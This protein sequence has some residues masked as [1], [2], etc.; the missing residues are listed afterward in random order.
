MLVSPFAFNQD[1]IASILAVRDMSK[2]EREFIEHI[3]I[4]APSDILQQYAP[5]E[6]L[7]LAEQM[8]QK[9]AV[10][11]SQETIIEFI[12]ASVPNKQIL[13]IVTEDKAFLVD[14]IKALLSSLNITA[15][16]TLHP[17]IKVKRN[18]QG[19]LENIYPAI[20]EEEGE[21]ESFFFTELTLGKQITYSELKAKLVQVLS[22]NEAAVSD[23]P[24][25]VNE[26]QAT[27]N[28]LSSIDRNITQEINEFLEWLRAGNY[29]FLGYADFE[30]STNDTPAPKVANALG[31]LREGPTYLQSLLSLDHPT[32][33][34]RIEL[35]ATRLNQS[36]PVGYATK[37]DDII[38]RFRNASGE[39]TSERHFIGFFSKAMSYQSVQ[40]IPVIRRKLA[41]IIEQSGLPR[42]S[43][44][45][46]EIVNIIESL[47]R[48]D[49]IQIPTEDL[50]RMAFEIYHFL[51]RPRIKL[52]TQRYNAKEFLSCIV[53]LPSAGLSNE[54]QTNIAN[55]L[56]RE[57]NGEIE[58][59]YSQI[60]NP[61]LGRLH[62]LLR[63]R[64]DLPANIATSE[65]ERQIATFIEPW[66]EQVSAHAEHHLDKKESD[67]LM[68]LYAQAFNS[69]YK[70]NVTNPSEVLEDILHLEKTWQDQHIKFNLVPQ[71]P[72]QGLYQ[73]RIYHNEGQ[74]ILS[75]VIPTLE[76]LQFKVVDYRSFPIA[77]QDAGNKLWLH[78]YQLEC[79][80]SESV[81]LELVKRYVEEA[82]EAIWD[83]H[84]SND[85]FNRLILSAGFPW[86]QVVLCRAMSRY[87]RQINFNVS[88]TYIAEVLVKY[89]KV[90]NLLMEYFYVKFDPRK[91]EYKNLKARQ[92]YLITLS[93]K[94]TSSLHEVATRS[95]EQVLIRYFD[96]FQAMLRTNFYQRVEGNKLK[97]YLSFKFNSSK[98]PDLV[99]P[100]PYAEIFVYSREVEG[101]H[102]RGGKVARGGLRYSDRSQDY[103]T[104]VLGLMKA[105]MAKNVVIIPEG[106]KGGFV[107]KTK[108][109]HLSKPEQQQR[110]VHC[111]QTYIRGLLDITD[112][113]VGDKC[114]GP[115]NVICYDGDDPYLVVAADKGT[116]TFSD[117]ANQIASEYNFWLGDAFASGGSV[118]Y[119]H[120]KMG[121]T[122]RG[123]WL[124]VVHHFSRLG[125]DVHT[126]PFTTVGIGDMSGDVFGNGML[127]SRQI[128]LVGAFNHMHIFLDPN[129]LPEVSFKERERLFQLPRSTWEDYNPDLISKG[130][131]IYPRTMRK[132]PLSLEVQK[133]LDVKKT[134]MSP[135]ELMS[136]LL[137]APVDL[138]WNGGIGT[139]VKASTES[140]EQVSDKANDGC[141]VNGN[142]LRAKVV[143]EGGNL[144][145]TQ[146]GRIEAA[147]NG[148]LLNTDAIDNSAGVDC[149]DHEV[150]IKIALSIATR[151]GELSL[152]GRNKLLAEMTDNVAEL[153]LEDNREQNL[154]ISLE[155]QAAPLKLVDH[156]RFI[157]YLAKQEL[158][159]P[160][161]EFLPD[162][163]EF[164]NRGLNQEGLTRPEIAILMAYSKIATYKDLLNTTLPDQ[165]ELSKWLVNYFPHAMQEKYLHVIK[166]HPLRR[167]IIATGVVNRITNRLGITFMTQT[168]QE[169]GC[170]VA[171]I[172]QAYLVIADAFEIEDKW[173]QVRQLPITTDFAVKL[174]SYHTLSK[175]VKRE[176]SWLLAQPS[177]LRKELLEVLTE[178]KNEIGQLWNDFEIKSG[179]ARK[180]YQSQLKLYS[181]AQL[182]ETLAKMMSKFDYRLPLISLAKLAKT[183]NKSLKEFADSYQYVSEEF[184]LSWILQRLAY[185]SATDYWHRLSTNELINQL[186]HAVCMLATKLLT[187]EANWWQRW[188]ESNKSIVGQFEETN[189]SLKHYKQFELSKAMVLVNQFK[190]VVAS[191]DV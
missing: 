172:I 190:Q 173:Q 68:T 167:E 50:L 138:I 146:R 57:F 64:N 82:L 86:H 58:Y 131:G 140:N 132:I 29:T 92:N 91:T 106:S 98:I 110:I 23:W 175:L 147:Q 133:M 61:N 184:F 59:R 153:V 81:K 36:S 88:T 26:L 120:K 84:M 109:N 17:I 9:A 151:A 41:T 130:G 104:E 73:L 38:I 19:Q 157:N 114:V 161:V 11:S 103:R 96:I 176:L 74:L 99:K 53:F 180:R 141:R 100:L 60:L 174:T 42:N 49:L 134:E 168:I 78:V 163:E 137:K 37:M 181:K 1:Q 75:S 56:A 65:L 129:P 158:L 111:Y 21:N 51:E 54:I 70:A 46:K 159:D 14:T 89:H 47:P 87:M 156:Q 113:L 155:A 165:E 182:P 62:I 125:I 43:H 15:N 28:L 102:L 79:E 112:N 107:I 154:I 63:L 166:Q 179:E 85:A 80:V 191:L 135:E 45:A 35:V 2:M 162:S 67:R 152:E 126:T 69:A 169:T 66:L 177:S 148:V 164:K 33:D 5:S 71:S 178:S 118:G 124:S 127:R 30:F 22:Y 144:G 143:G 117:I 76:D 186:E 4:H 77:R 12:P 83:G 185:L 122:A 136:A 10:R 3:F 108:I 25:I 39:V 6:W 16:F 13:L 101:I 48:Y 34:R 115:K 150:N 18:S 149:S 72:E 95:E 119:D 170:N 32:S 31:V 189:I 94:I 171:E 97:R 142:Q 123:A 7:K 128:K 24:K 188:R 93:E 183:Y 116:A 52:F 139:Y 145:F 8:R 44:G 90:T 27:S 20:S 55:S 40:Q 187:S 121:I 105:Q 160:A